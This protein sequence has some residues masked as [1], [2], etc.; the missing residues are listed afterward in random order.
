MTKEGF[1]ESDSEAASRFITYKSRDPF[2]NIAP[3]LLNSADV[4]DYIR[5]T[6]MV[7]PFD[8]EGKRKGATVPLHVGDTVISWGTGGGDYE[9]TTLQYGS[10][11]KMDRNSIVFVKTL[12]K[13]RI[14]KYMVARF[15]LRIDHVHKGLLFGTGTV[16]DPGYV[17]HLLVPIHNLT[18]NN[19]RVCMGSAFAWME[20]TKISPHEGVEK[21]YGNSFHKEATY[22]D[23]IAEFEEVPVPQMLEKAYTGEIRSSI[24]DEIK[25]AKDTSYEAKQLSNWTLIGVIAVLVG[26]LSVVAPIFIYMDE[27]IEH[28]R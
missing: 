21:I 25:S 28:L 20:F 26:F 13:L 16:V 14:P 18:V 22:P 27:K 12:E 23:K 17:G 10:C 19:Y 4:I 15:N 24:P 11:R 5:L 8:P 2:Y 1:A 6:G 7:H 9:E 3:A